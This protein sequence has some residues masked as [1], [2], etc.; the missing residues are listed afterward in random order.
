MLYS[1]DGKAEGAV[2]NITEAELEIIAE[3]EG[4]PTK[5]YK[6]TPSIA[7]VLGWH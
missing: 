3:K 5:A 6:R 1:R 7:R 4:E 2:F